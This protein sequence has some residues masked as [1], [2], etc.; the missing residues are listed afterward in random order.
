MASVPSEGPRLGLRDRPAPGARAS[1]CRLAPAPVG[2]HSQ[3]VQRGCTGQAGTP[4]SSGR[5]KHPPRC[6]QAP[7][8]CLQNRPTP[9]PLPATPS[10]MAPVQLPASLTWITA[11]LL[12]G[13]HVYSC[14]HQSLLKIRSRRPLPQPHGALSYHRKSPEGPTPLPPVPRHTA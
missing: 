3:G 4:A 6:Q 12:T 1:P 8:C 14:P 13:P 10:A 7:W 5:N 2:P 9:P 11:N